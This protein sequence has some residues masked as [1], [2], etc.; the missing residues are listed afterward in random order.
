MLMDSVLQHYDSCAGTYNK[1]EIKN[2]FCAWFL[3]RD[4]IAELTTWFK[5]FSQVQILVA[6]LPLKSM[7]FSIF[8]FLVGELS[9]KP[10]TQ[11]LI[12][13]FRLLSCH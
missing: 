6:R 2:E 13:K 7:F 11:I 9:V 5:I 8:N 4:F 10:K 3:G 1:T 12:F